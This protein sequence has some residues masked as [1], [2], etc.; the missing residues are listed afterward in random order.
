MNLTTE[1]I[2]SI[3]DA[4]A[5]LIENIKITKSSV[6]IS[7][8]GSH[9]PVDK[10]PSTHHQGQIVEDIVIP[11]KENLIK[12]F[13]TGVAKDQIEEQQLIDELFIT[14]PA[15]YEDLVTMKEIKDGGEEEN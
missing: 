4:G 2:I 13:P 7:F 15:A 5:G 11:E 3:I 8:I 14:N 12:D 6:E 1:Q 10:S 9:K